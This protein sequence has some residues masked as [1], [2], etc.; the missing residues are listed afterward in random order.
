MLYM[1]MGRTRDIT[2]AFAVQGGRIAPVFDTADRAT[3]VSLDDH[4]RTTRCEQP[5]EP[6]PARALLRLREGGVSA[7][8][9]GAIS[10]P[11]EQVAA[12]CGLRLVSFVAGELDE[13]VR[14]WRDGRL[15]DGRFAMPG[16]RAR[17]GR[18]TRRGRG[19]QNGYGNG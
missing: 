12:S 14:A 18:R 7:L 8:V 10:R 19:G 6:P 5:L 9:C 1:G 13:V 16:C 11:M 2:T 15:D 17:R 3:I 4:G